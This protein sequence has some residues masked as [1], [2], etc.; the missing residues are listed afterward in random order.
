MAERVGTCKQELKIDILSL[1]M[2][3]WEEQVG[4]DHTLAL[5]HSRRWQYVLSAREVYCILERMDYFSI[6]V[7]QH[8][9][10]A[11]HAELLCGDKFKAIWRQRPRFV[12]K[13]G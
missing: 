5:L 11:E 6:S 13:K 2:I 4:A 9:V 8:V 10:N 1:Q 7:S 12:I 3:Y